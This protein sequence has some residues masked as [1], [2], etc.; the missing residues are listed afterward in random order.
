MLAPKC[1]MVR[2]PAAAGSF[3]GA[4]D[5][6]ALALDASL[7]VKMARRTDGMVSMRY[8]GEQGELIPRGPSNRVVESIKAA[9]DAKVRQF[10]G[11]DFEIYSS[12]P[13][14]VGLGA[15][16]AAVLAGLIAADRL[17]QLGFDEKQLLALA[18]SLDPRHDSL[19]AA[20]YGGLVIRDAS[21]NGF[22]VV[23]A[24]RRY[25][26]SVVIPEGAHVTSAA[27]PTGAIADWRERAAQ[28]PGLMQA[29]PGGPPA[30]IES[31]PV[32]HERTAPGLA[33]ALKLKYRGVVSA[34][35]CGSGPAL[36]LLSWG[37]P[38]A[39]EEQ[40]VAHFRSFG[41]NSRVARFR[42]I[43]EGAREWN[44]WEGHAPLAADCSS[45]SLP[46]ASMTTS[47]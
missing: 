5:C 42:P 27:K 45:L 39:A 6:A 31:L 14:G 41:V 16:T 20:W 12:I 8:F 18:A 47:A 24:T 46:A 28:L 15:S 21:G 34:F 37:E 2:V 22:S 33:E 13:V 26:L 36:G 29:A 1:V 44:Q 23:A 4:M 40:A 43:N 32:S 9:L 25:C 38:A 19:H 35:V 7:N 11:G 30:A 17:Y 10:T 3:A